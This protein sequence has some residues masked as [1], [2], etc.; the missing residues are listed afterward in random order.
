MKRRKKVLFITSTL[1]SGGITQVLYSICKYMDYERFEVFVL[2]LS[3]EP[4][5]TQLERFKGL[6]IHLESLNL[7]RW[8]ALF[9]LKK[10]LQEKAAQIQP[11]IVHTFT[12]RPSYYAMKYLARFQRLVTLSSNLKPN[13]QKTYGKW[14]GAFIAHQE[15]KA[16]LRA[17][18]KSVVSFTLA[19]KYK[20]VPGI[21]VI[22]NGADEELFF[23]VGEEQKSKLRDKL[24]FGKD[25]QIFLSVGA[26]SQLKDPLTLAKAFQK[27]KLGTNAKLVFVGTG[28]EWNTLKSITQSDN[29]I[30]LTGY[31]NNAQE[32]LQAA[33][34]FVSCSHS[35][36]LPNTVIEAGLCGL[37]C[38]LSNIPQHKEVNP[39]AGFFACSDVLALQKLLEDAETMPFA[40]ASKKLTAHS[41]TQAYM[42]LYE[43][44][45]A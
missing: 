31:K 26:L 33:D 45:N 20:I 3:P 15:F 29:R 39:H 25:D 5:N 21:H 13:Y 7:S 40:N 38:L 8:E 34:V 37:K 12:Y 18:I 30:L 9:K 22:Q 35:E 44:S 27:A 24:G 6:P 17:D 11:D 2:T 16:F 32:Y 43:R 23:K 19:E 42:N 28:T 41:M 14:L 4:S 1:E 10:Q 36:G